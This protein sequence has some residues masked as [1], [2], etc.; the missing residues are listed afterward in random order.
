MLQ[1]YL[2]YCLV[3]PAFVAL[4]GMLIAGRLPLNW[5]PPGAVTVILWAC[6]LS[7]FLLLGKNLYQPER[8]WH[9]LPTIAGW[10]WLV[11][12]LGFRPGSHW[13]ERGLWALACGGLAGYLLVP[14]WADLAEQRIWLR[15]GLAGAIGLLILLGDWL[16]R[17]SRPLLVLVSFAAAALV[18]AAWI[19][20]GYSLTNSRWL[21]ILAA[22]VA[23]TMLAAM[24]PVPSARL[25]AGRMLP[26][27]ASWLL[28]GLFIGAIEPNPP[29]YEI[30]FL[31]SLPLAL[32]AAAAGLRTVFQRP[33]T[34]APVTKM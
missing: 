32:L 11:G 29:R 7:G 3:V 21:L 19:G 18:G 17:S 26:L 34:D 28:G 2:G 15:V 13:T 30:L 14:T 23:G 24:L 22:A 10:S 8:H 25:D 27:L 12:V 5:Q 6:L 20:A 31:A 16:V 33:E 4:V 9:W 1:E